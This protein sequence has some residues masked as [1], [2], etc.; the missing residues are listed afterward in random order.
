MLEYE[1]D[2]SVT[3]K[4]EKRKFLRLPADPSYLISAHGYVINR[5][6]GILLFQDSAPPSTDL[7]LRLGHMFY[8]SHPGTRSVRHY[9]MYLYVS[10]AVSFLRC[11]HHRFFT[12]SKTS[13]IISIK[14]DSD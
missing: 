14:Q 12:N 6:L 13:Q 8:D 9:S 1:H 4:W 3:D 7:F 2:P 11:F 10:T 5:G